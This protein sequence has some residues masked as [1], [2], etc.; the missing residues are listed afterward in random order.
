MPAE[1][2]A[3]MPERRRNDLLR[4]V[5]WR[6]LLSRRDA[7]RAAGSAAGT[8]AVRLISSGVTDEP[9]SA[10]LA[11]IGFPSRARL[12]T[13]TAALAPGGDLVCFWR[14]PQPGATRRARRRLEAAGL[15]GVRV[16]WAGP[17]PHRAPQFWLEL[18]SRMATEHLLAS[19]AARSR[20]QAALR[21]VWRWALRAGLLA[22]QCAVARVPDG[23][24]PNQKPLLLLTGGRRSI[25]K[26]VGLEFAPEGAGPARAVKFARV[27]EAEPGLEREAMVLGRLTESRPDLDGY[28]RLEGRL[29]RCGM[30]GVAESPIEGEP[31]IEVL[32]PASFAGLADRVKGFLVEL[33]VGEEERPESAWRSR[34]VDE[35]LE[36]F[37]RQFGEVAPA[38]V[39]QLRDALDRFGDLPIVC[40]HRDCSPWNI[41]IGAGGDPSLFDWES[42]EPDGLPGLDLVYFLANCAFVIDGALES[43]RT[44]ESYASLLDPGT[45]NG[46]VAAE[47]LAS[48]A[49]AVGLDDAVL[50]RLRLLCWVIHSR[51]DYRHLELETGGAPDRDALRGAPFLGLLEEEL[52]RS[53]RR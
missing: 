8:E 7:P 46:R 48:Y 24:Q 33:A 39:D 43:G 20:G 34:L 50:R 12:R 1:A 21:R 28:P 18:D 36:L 37:A 25:N 49:R 13:A 47:S 17:V 3:E 2:S 53:H 9:G 27:R 4:G 16:F 19:R 10:E 51:S 52:D 5:D 38:M 31:L 42:A 6:F 29:R 32:T 22:P 23:E 44:R 11:V 15:D 30:F 14:L 35:P 26:V 45:A 41:A 40:E